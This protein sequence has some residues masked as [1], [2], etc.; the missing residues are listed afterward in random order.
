LI[1]I[2]CRLKECKR[3]YL[4]QVS[5]GHSDLRIL[6]EVLRSFRQ[7]SGLSQE[8][9]AEKAGLHRTYIGGV[10]RGERNVTFLT[11]SRILSAAGVTWTRLAK[12]L[13]GARRS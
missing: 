7:G 3:A 10:E 8:G 6:G 12:A 11:L 9:F 5:R 2:V 1:L 13:D 4:V